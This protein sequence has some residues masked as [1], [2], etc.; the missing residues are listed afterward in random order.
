[1][2]T[3]KKQLDL[4]EEVQ[5]VEHIFREFI[6]GKFQI[7]LDKLNFMIKKSSGEDNP[8]LFNKTVKLSGL[9][10]SLQSLDEEVST[11]FSDIERSIEEAE[12]S[13]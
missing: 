1:M 3:K 6:D 4:L 5:D 9:M 10:M 8:G 7:E 13:F 11:A 12:V 2:L